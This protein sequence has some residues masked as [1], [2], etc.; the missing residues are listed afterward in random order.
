MKRTSKIGKTPIH[1]HGA[2]GRIFLPIFRWRACVSSKECKSHEQ[3]S[4]N[5][6]QCVFCENIHHTPCTMYISEPKYSEW[7]NQRIFPW[8]IILPLNCL[9]A[10]RTFLQTSVYYI[11]CVFY[12]WKHLCNVYFISENSFANNHLASPL[13]CD[14]TFL[15]LES[16]GDVA[17]RRI[18]LHQFQLENSSISFSSR[19]F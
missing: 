9:K 1:I 5:K 19:K 7:E 11:K 18:C 12:L 15:R 17:R 3:Y 13:P 14:L 16:I 2:A 10:P 6:H 8:E 4:P